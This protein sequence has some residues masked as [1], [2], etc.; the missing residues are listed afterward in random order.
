MTP[1]ERAAYERI[2][3]LADRLAPRLRTAL[4]AVLRSITGAAS[5]RALEQAIER[6]GAEAV[7][8]LFESAEASA[9][10]AQLRATYGAAVYAAAAE[11]TRLL[12][13]LGPIGALRVQFP[14]T[15]PSLAVAVQAWENDAFARIRREMRDGIRET[16]AREIA[17]GVNPRQVAVA[18]KSPTSAVGLTAYD[19]QIVDSFRAALTGG[20]DGIPSREALGRM[21]RDRRSDPVLARAIRAG[22]PLD[23]ATVDRMVGAYRRKLVAWRAETFAR[24]S[25]IDAA[26]AG[27]LAAWQA[28][29][30]AGVVA[31]TAVRRYWIV[32]PDE[33][34][35]PTCAP[36]PGLNADGV[37][38]DGTFRTPKGAKRIPTLHP[39]CRCVVWV[40]LARTRDRRPA[41]GTL[42]LDPR[43]GA[44][45]RVFDPV[46]GTIP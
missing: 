30:D 11:T 31:A 26:N 34:L 29:V 17:R 32:S 15:S 37:A 24:T 33:R 38:L 14:V 2:T 5:L 7:L 4:L 19:A 28:Q 3:R 25:A 46:T 39:N 45:V 20:R 35:C 6:Q 9:A 42:R 22:R 16:V 44:V 36:V 10:L 1:A 18:L 12:P 27:Q 13:R 23:E 40:R 8:G 21:L 43:T 41:P